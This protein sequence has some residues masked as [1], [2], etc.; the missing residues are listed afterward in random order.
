TSRQIFLRQAT[1]AVRS[2]AVPNR[3]WQSIAVQGRR[4]R[5]QSEICRRARMKVALVLSCQLLGN[6]MTYK[7]PMNWDLHHRWQ[8]HAMVSITAPLASASFLRHSTKSLP[9]RL[10]PSQTVP[11]I[12]GVRKESLPKPSPTERFARPVGSI[13]DPPREVLRH[14][15]TL[16]L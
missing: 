5:E 11:T 12:R 1:R 15:D 10:I 9:R 4:Q 6:R 13:C 14:F 2:A 3:G 8:S 7:R 16:R